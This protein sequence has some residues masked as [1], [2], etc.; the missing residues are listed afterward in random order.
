MPEELHK[1]HCIPCEGGT[2]PLLDIDENLLMKEV[3]GW[4]LDR[5]SM[6]KLKRIFTFKDFKEAMVFVNKIANIAEEEGHHPDLY[7]FYNQVHIELYTHAVGGLSKNDFIVAS[8][9]N[10]I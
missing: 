7:I 5:T 2:P 10:K 6:H 1:I 8:K 3:P 4:N 9:I